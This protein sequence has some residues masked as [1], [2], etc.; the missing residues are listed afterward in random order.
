MADTRL[1]YSGNHPQEVV[2]KG[3]SV[4]LAPGE[5]VEL[6]ADDMKN[7]AVKDMMDAG[8]LFKVEAGEKSNG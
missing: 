6:D 4:M 2:A 5:F 8:T 7:P 1:R 3:K